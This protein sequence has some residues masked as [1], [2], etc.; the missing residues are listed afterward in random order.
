MENGWIIAGRKTK[1]IRKTRQPK[2][3]PIHIELEELCDT[4]R[5]ILSPYT[6]LIVAS[7]L[8]GSRA[9][10]TNRPDSDADLL[11]F[12]KQ[13]L[14]LKDLCLIRSEIEEAL[15]IQT[16][17]VSCIVRKKCISHLDSRDDAYFGNVMV[18]AIQFMGIERLDDLI[19]NSVK[20]PKL[21]R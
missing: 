13:Q 5:E 2:A 15:G 16:D 14:N 11:I 8:Y 21:R 18:D 6:N 12:W 1:N 9:R 20:L 4:L 3:E 7:F 10:K 19:F 17:F